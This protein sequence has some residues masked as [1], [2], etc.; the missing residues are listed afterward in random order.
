MELKPDD[1]IKAF[2]GVR[3]YVFGYGLGRDN[4]HKDDKKTAETW[5]AEGA[6]LLVAIM[7]FYEQMS[8][9]HEKFLRFGNAKD[10]SYLPASLKVFNENIEAALR[11]QKSGGQ[12]DETEKAYS[13]WRSRC[14]GW[15]KDKRLWQINM[16][17]PE[18]FQEGNRVP[19]SILQELTKHAA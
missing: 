7:V 1:L 5:I 10:R 13:L 17:G 2:D 18:P 15:L 6:T 3:E 11:R 4:P 19:K 14:K 9:M 16:W 8:W 12:T